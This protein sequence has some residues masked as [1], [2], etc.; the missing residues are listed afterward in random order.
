M[1]HEWLPPGVSWE[2]HIPELRCS[3]YWQADEHRLKTEKAAMLQN[4][5]SHCADSVRMLSIL[6]PFGHHS[7]PPSHVVANKW[8]SQESNV[9][10]P[11]TRGWWLIKGI[12]SKT[13]ATVQRATTKMNDTFLYSFFLGINFN[14]LRKQDQWALGAHL[15]SYTVGKV[16]YWPGMSKLT[17]QTVRP[18]HLTRFTPQ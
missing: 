9:V 10:C 13:K 18:T 5:L 11:G 17:N 7:S 8:R 6:P 14:F 4:L 16:C 3:F 2:E 15:V 12:R 1:L